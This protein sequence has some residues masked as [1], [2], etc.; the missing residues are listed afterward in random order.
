MTLDLP[1]ESLEHARKY[2]EELAVD[3]RITAIAGPATE[4]LVDP[5]EG[6]VAMP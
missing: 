3:D 4:T 6:D 1:C 2:F 5:F